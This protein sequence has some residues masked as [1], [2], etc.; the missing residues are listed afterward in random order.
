MADP[1][2]R[3][4]AV[5]TGASSGIGLEL[6]KQFADNGFDLIIAAEDAGIQDA[7]Q[8]LETH[9]AHVEA[10]QV[11]LA[12]HDGVH[13]LYER[14]QAAGRP[15]DAIALNAGVGV[16]GAFIDTD[17]DEEMNLIN[18]NVVS[19]VHLAKHVI[20]DM[21]ARGQGRVL[22]TASIASLSPGPFFAVYSASK[23]FVYS[24]AQSIR[25]ELKDTGVS[26]T[27]LLPGATDTNF[28]SRADME[29]T[30]AGVSEKDDPAQVAKQGFDALMA[31]DDHVVGGKFMNKVQATLMNVMSEPAKAAQMRKTVE[32]GSADD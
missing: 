31:G 25:N 7:A 4:L 10:V 14:I 3:Q 17:L 1:T 2:G 24:F 5:V 29:D 19:V 6:A 22:F 21:A 23:A 28:F 12:A 20:K 13:T 30:K 18:L 15:V 9:G 27:A 16:N 26:V 11:D 32:P 8:T